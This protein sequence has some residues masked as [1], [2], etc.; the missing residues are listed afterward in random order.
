MQT[1]LATVSMLWIEGRLSTLETLSIRSFLQCGHPVDLYTYDPGLIA[2]QG[3]RLCDANLIVPG[4]QRFRSATAVGKGSWGPFSDLFRFSLL[5]QRGGIWCDTDIICLKPLDFV[6]QGTYF[7]SEHVLTQGPNGAATH[8]APT[9]CFIAAPLGE[10]LIAECLRR[11]AAIGRHQANWADSGPGVVQA[12]IGE[13]QRLDCV[14]QPDIFCSV[15][16]WDVQRLI[17]G[18]HTI[19]PV[20]YGLHLW[21]EVWRWNFLDKD[22]TYEPLSI[23]ERLKRH[24][25]TDRNA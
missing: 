3:V 18:F 6:A 9:T 21:N 13:A 14:L 5:Q 25:L 4:D 1:P 10:P 17:H 20:A 15:P 8:P 22:M 2:P 23:L 24:Y 11:T 12:V 16:H 19:N 7:A